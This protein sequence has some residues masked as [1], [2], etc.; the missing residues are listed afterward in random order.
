MTKIINVSTSA[1]LYA[2]LKTVTGGE[3]ILLAGGDYGNLVMNVKSDFNLNFPS[4]ITIASAD[5]SDPAVFSKLGL[6]AVSNLTIDGVVF[7][8]KFAPG[9]L[10][11]TRP[12]AINN[13]QNITIINSTFDGDVAS[14]VSA[15]SDGYGAAVGLSVR[16]STGVTVQNNEF[17]SWHRGLVVQDA[18]NVKVIGNDVHDIRS[19]GMDFVDVQKVLIEDNYI[20]DFRASYA[21]SDHRDMIQFWTSGTTTPSTDITIRGN[22]LDIGDGAYTQSIFM[23]NEMVDTKQAGHEMFYKNI[24]IE[25]NTIYNGHLHGITVGETNGLTIRNNSVI[26]VIDENNPNQNGSGV[27]IPTIRVSRLSENVAITGNAVANIEGHTGQA[28]WTLYKNAFIQNS[29]PFLPG[30]YGDVF[31]SSSLGGDAGA[32]SYI[33]MS[34]GML[35]LLKA[36]SSDT[37]FS[38]ALGNAEALYTVKDV[39]DDGS[40]RVFDASL[41][42]KAFG[43]L[44]LTGATYLWSFGDGTTATGRVVSHAFADGGNYDVSLKIKL[45]NG[46]FLTTSSEVG[47][48]GADVIS[49]NRATGSFQT[50]ALGEETTSNTNRL[51]NLDQGDLQLGAPGV[52]ATVGRGALTALRGSDDFAI[53]FSLQGDKAGAAGEVFRLQSNFLASVSLTGQMK[54]Q[55]FLADGKIVSLL[56]A[57]GMKLN[58][59]LEHDVSIRV[60]DGRLVITIDG[61]IAGQTAVS[62]TLPTSG[63]ADL[64][65]GNAWGKPNFAGDISAFEIKVD[66]DDYKAGPHI[67][68]LLTEPVKPITSEPVIA[69]VEQQDAAQQ[70]AALHEDLTEHVLDIKGLAGSKTALLDDA[71]VVQ[72][73]DGPVIHLDGDKDHVN[74][75]RMVDME[76][77]EKVAF[78]VDFSR[79]G[80]ATGEERLVWNHMKLGLTLV[81]DGLRLQ[82]GTADDGF[83][84]FTVKD[85]GLNDADLHRATVMVDAQNDRLQVVLDD[86]VV[87][88]VKD[89]DLDIVGAGGHEW[90]WTLGTAWNR[91]FEGDISDFR[92]GDRFEFLDGYSD[93][94]QTA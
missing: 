40:A 88:D 85:L 33:A 69:P 8:Y 38:A 79:D 74:L 55:L 10:L 87:L 68:A 83:K 54:F 5:P 19:D 93:T 64:T 31:V 56:T 9:D 94:P 44:D 1:E 37:A 41:T 63:T 42:A 32:H 59:G 23:R 67:A 46:S 77:S 82:V 7:D 35:D 47:I 39:P 11:T 71:K 78:S 24:L 73:A 86:Q 4:N 6:N 26:A 51:A 57:P 49:F 75:G 15:Y 34:G 29:N 84:A 60:N 13:S 81:D 25:D 52:A 28:G 76:Q 72:T 36:G 65:F 45:P 27:W 21:S 12:N 30:Y 18:Q 20:H 16:G 70:V 22:T 3:K 58:D 53:N 61:D 80:A 62:G 48:N 89:I 2:A 50:F 92:L 91:Y 90:G 14:G 43:A 17:F 66:V